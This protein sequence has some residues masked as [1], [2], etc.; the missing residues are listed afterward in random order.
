MKLNEIIDAN[1]ALSDFQ[2]EVLVLAAISATP[3][4]AFDAT[5]GNYNLISAR[6]IL[7]NIGMI[8]VN[9]GELALTQKGQDAVISN[10]LIDDMNQ[11]TE[12]SKLLLKNSK[13]KVNPDESE[14]VSQ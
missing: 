1:Y 9:N 6:N 3:K 11:P 5:I 7:F 12:D 8:N 14:D 10:N 2:K 4:Q 13:V